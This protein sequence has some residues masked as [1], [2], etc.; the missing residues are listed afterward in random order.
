MAGALNA[1][2]L[3]ESESTS[4]ENVFTTSETANLN[5]EECAKFCPPNCCKGA[6]ATSTA[7]S[8]SSVESPASNKKC[9]G[10]FPVGCCNGEGAKATNVSAKDSPQACASSKKKCCKKGA[11]LQIAEVN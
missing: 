4:T 3:L 2:T 5:P 6:K 1:Q 7:Q 9:C 10:I 8:V 11:A